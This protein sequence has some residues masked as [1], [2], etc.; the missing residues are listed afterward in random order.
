M[1]PESRQY[2]KVLGARITQLRKERDMTQAELARAIGVSQQRV[3]AYELGDRRV[4]VLMLVKLARLFQIS[5]EQLMGIAQPPPD[6]ER[7]SSKW[8]HQA[9]RMR[10]RSKRDQRFIIKIIDVL[11]HGRTR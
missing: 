1:K 5:V 3:F 6:A 7:P 8:L 10:G 11:E 9:Q 4:C 2:F